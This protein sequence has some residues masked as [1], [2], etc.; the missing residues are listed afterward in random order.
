[1][2]RAFELEPSLS[3]LA[4]VLPSMKKN[5]SRHKTLITF[6]F[7]DEMSF[8]DQTWS[9]HHFSR[10]SDQFDDDQKDMNG[11][12]SCEAEAEAMNDE[13]FLK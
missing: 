9:D 12:R 13:Q 1:M 8:D 5:T 2:D 4:R 10:K 11:P 3:H 6:A 7:L